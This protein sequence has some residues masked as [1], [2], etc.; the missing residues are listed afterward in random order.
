MS[1]IKDLTGQIFSRLK[2]LRFI[3]QDKQ[4]HTFWLCRCLCDKKEVAVRG[5]G[6]VSGHAR[7]CGC[8]KREQMSQLRRKHGQSGGKSQ[9]S[10]AYTSWNNM[11]N[12]CTNPNANT[13]KWYGGAPVPVLCCDRWLNSFEN[14]LADMGERPQ[15]T[16]LGRFG[17]FGD[18][19]PGN[20]SWETPKQ[21]GAAQRLK[22]QIKRLVTA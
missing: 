2:V 11:I 1:A 19:E 3:S 15:G 17:D 7:S 13:C 21:Q 8:I 22:N 6:L 12:R 20:V 5:D 4:W 10:R 9:K 14:F 18:Y 16:S